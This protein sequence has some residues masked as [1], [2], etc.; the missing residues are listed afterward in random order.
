MMSVALVAGK[1]QATGVPT[2]SRDRTEQGL[3]GLQL[4]A[5]SA[6]RGSSPP[7]RAM[8]AGNRSLFGLPRGRVRRGGVP[9]V[10]P[11]GQRSRSPP[12]DWPM[13]G[14]A[15]DTAGR[16]RALGRL[17]AVRGWG[18]ALS[19]PSGAG[20]PR[21]GAWGL[22]EVRCRGAHSAPPASPQPGISPQK[23]GRGGRI[24]RTVKNTRA[25]QARLRIIV[26]PPLLFPSLLGSGASPKT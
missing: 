3:D 21:L 23:C 13:G 7:L 11:I 6:A 19:Q 8:A 20:P 2:K 16:A 10:P 5:C 17:A 26:S 14:A 24:L 12:A 9:P 25:C 18:R 22:W 15:G 1:W 4:P